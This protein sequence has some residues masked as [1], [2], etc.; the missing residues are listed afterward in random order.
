MV[1]YVEPLV[2]LLKTQIRQEGEAWALGF[3]WTL[4][5]LPFLR[6]Y[7]RKS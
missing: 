4:E 6:T 1:A 3:T 5:N 7:I 2:I